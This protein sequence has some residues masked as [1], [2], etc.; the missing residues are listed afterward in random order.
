MLF[1]NS[2]E[3]YGNRFS[4]PN[5][6]YQLGL[7]SNA[8]AVYGYL[9]SRENR[10]RGDRDRYTCYPSYATIG[11]AIGRS[12]RSVEK[13]VAE[14]V[15]AELI[16][17]ERTFVN[18]KDGQ[19]WNGNLRYTILPISQAVELYYERQLAKLNTSARKKRK[20]KRRQVP[21]AEYVA[22]HTAHEPEELPF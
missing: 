17:T 12:A 2:A 4:M 11:A 7:S 14:L 9:L 15:E 10:R 8:I 1:N 19:R 18:K 21:H 13:Y 5:E 16:L 20:R 22:S 6:V 3:H